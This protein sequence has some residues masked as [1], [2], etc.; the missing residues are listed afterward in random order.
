MRR[1]PE[2]TRSLDGRRRVVVA[3]S[4]RANHRPP[5]ARWPAELPEQRQRRSESQH[6]LGR[7]G[8]VAPL[9]RGVEVVVF[10]LESREAFR[11]VAEREARRQPLGE[12][13]EVREVPG[14]NRVGLARL[15]E[16]GL[17][18]L[19]DRLEH[20]VAVDSASS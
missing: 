7:G 17:E 13:E 10:G 1:A 9:E 11:S 14:A 4:T 19:T 5:L 18:E 6:L 2:C 16:P 12:I 20:P 3:Q 15:H 8:T